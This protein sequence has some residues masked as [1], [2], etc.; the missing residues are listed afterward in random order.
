MA[1]FHCSVRSN[2]LLTFIW[3]FT[4]TKSE[5]SQVIADLT[6][7]YIP[8]KYSVIIGQTSSRL[9]VHRVQASDAGSYTCRVSANGEIFQA[10][11]ILDILCKHA[12]CM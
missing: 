10:F 1:D 12:E 11:A 9:Q 4:L 7:P 8:D 2:F 6:G 5:Q 3:E